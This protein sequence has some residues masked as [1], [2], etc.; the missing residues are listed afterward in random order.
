MARDLPSGTLTF[1]FTDVEGSTRLL[2]LFPHQYG[3]IVET[4]RRLISV[5]LSSRTAAWSSGPKAMRCS[6]RSTP[7][8]DAV[9]AAV[10][11]SR[12]AGNTIGRRACS[13]AVRMGL[14]TGDAEV[15]DDDYVGLALHVAARSVAPRRTS[16]DLR[17]DASPGARH[18][19][20]R[21]RGA[22]VARCR[23]A[24]AP[25]RGD[26]RGAA[27]RCSPPRTLSARPNNLPASTDEF[28]GR[29]LEMVDVA[30]GR[31]GTADGHTLRTGRAVRRASSRSVR[32]CCRGSRTVFGSWT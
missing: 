2:S 26:G 3:E 15:I 9:N 32:R 10:E 30:E 24:G 28:V 1:L 17:A 25:L 6:S 8:T 14:H 13:C 18:V 16:A 21:T 29:R 4:Q 20:A 23:V 27:P 31:R 11:A 19:G 22:S 7:A 5:P 12:A